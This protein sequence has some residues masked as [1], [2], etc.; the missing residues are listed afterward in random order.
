MSVCVK[1]LPCNV[2]IC[3]IMHFIFHVDN[4]VLVQ[5][6]SLE[7]IL[8]DF[9]FTDIFDSYFHSLSFS[10]RLFLYVVLLPM[11]AERSRVY[12][13]WLDEKRTL[14][15]NYKMPLKQF[16]VE[17]LAPGELLFFMVY[18]DRLYETKSISWSKNGKQIC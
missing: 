1:V 13:L 5:C 11:N 8:I 9:H 18:R 6:T 12:Q 16:S 10:S 17:N 4:F 7:V 15:M 2:L 3:Q 14:R